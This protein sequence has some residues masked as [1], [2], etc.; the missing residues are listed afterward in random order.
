MCYRCGRDR[1]PTAVSPGDV[2]DRSGHTDFN[3]SEATVV[4]RD[5]DDTVAADVGAGRVSRS[6]ANSA[7]K[8]DTVDTA[9]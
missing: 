9:R 1:P 3:D 7:K 6:T 4:G 8:S 2:G 5:E